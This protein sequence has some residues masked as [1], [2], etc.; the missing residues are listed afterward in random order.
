MPLDLIMRT[1]SS[2][3]DEHIQ[4]TMAHTEEDTPYN[5]C[6]DLRLPDLPQD[7]SKELGGQ[8]NNTCRAAC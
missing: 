7:Q 2:Q 8:D 4:A 1:I 6:Y 3:G 5:F